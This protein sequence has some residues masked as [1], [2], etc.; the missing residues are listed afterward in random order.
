[1]TNGPSARRWFAAGQ[2]DR[3]AG[4]L[5]LAIG[6]GAIVLGW[7][8]RFGSLSHMGSG[9]FPVCVGA[10]L[11]LLGI[12]IA[13]RAGGASSRDDE[14][15]RP[16]AGTPSWRGWICVP[17][18]IA[19]FVV[20]GK[21]G[22]LLPATFAITFIGA[23]ADQQNS[24]RAALSLALLMSLVAIVVFHWALQIQFPLLSWG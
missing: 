24:L 20:L 16:A 21:W 8:Y 5:I 11:A 17:G 22:G 1:M 19:A 9:F 13:A 14:P 6:V 7:N 12:A 23:L 15:A 4:M 2:R 18:S 10:A 3:Y